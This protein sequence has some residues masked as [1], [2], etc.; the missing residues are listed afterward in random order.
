MRTIS[1]IWITFAL[2]AAYAEPQASSSDHRTVTD[3]QKPNDI[4]TAYVTTPSSPKKFLMLVDT[5]VSTTH[6]SISTA[7][8]MGVNPTGELEPL[9][10]DFE[11]KVV[12]VEVGTDVDLAPVGKPDGYVNIRPH[13]SD[14]SASESEIISNTL[15]KYDGVLG[16]DWISKIAF[17]MDFKTKVIEI[18]GLAKHN[19]EE[20]SIIFTSSRGDQSAIF[21]RTDLFGEFTLCY[22]DT[23]DIS[24]EGI[25]IPRNSSLY[26]LVFKRMDERKVINASRESAVAGVVAQSVFSDIGIDGLASPNGILVELELWSENPPKWAEN[27]ARNDCSI[28]YSLLK[29]SQIVHTLSGKSYV[30]GEIDF[31][32]DRTGITGYSVSPSGDVLIN[33]VLTDSPADAAGLRRGDQLIAINDKPIVNGAQI[34]DALYLVYQDA[35]TSVKVTFEQNYFDEKADE[36]HHV[37][38]V[39]SDVLEGDYVAIRNI[40]KS[41]TR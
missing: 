35:G 15:S 20:Q 9:N 14:P 27:G 3:T 22:V 12:R 4:F 11:N 13:I 31:T 24:S 2:L 19:V 30:K 6:L 18:F 17:E 26:D 28:G 41:P 23:E 37:D 5:G 38:L 7:S 16:M 33:G 29:N 21:L 8:S 40:P 10:V 25:F 32:Y 39:L 36:L 1:L 34:T